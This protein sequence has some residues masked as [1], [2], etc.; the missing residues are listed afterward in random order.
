MIIRGIAA[1]PDAAISGMFCWAAP[2]TAAA[3]SLCFTVMIARSARCWG[4]SIAVT[5]FM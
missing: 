2:S 3:M 5:I 4:F 1:T